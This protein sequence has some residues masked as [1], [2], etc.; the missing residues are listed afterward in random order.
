MPEKKSTLNHK[1]FS[2]ERIKILSSADVSAVDLY[3]LFMSGIL[4]K[5]SA[6]IINSIEDRLEGTGELTRMVLEAL[7]DEGDIREKVLEKINEKTD[8]G[9]QSD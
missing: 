8:T 5:K 3:F 1:Y 9:Y 4:G 7:R 6:G 2:T